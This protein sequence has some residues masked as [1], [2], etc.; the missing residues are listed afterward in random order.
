M[1]EI[2]FRT[3]DTVLKKWNL[4]TTIDCFGTVQEYKYNGHSYNAK[5]A[6]EYN[7]DE[8]GHLLTD[9]NL[10]FI[11]Q[12]YTGFKDNTGKEVYEGDI[13]KIKIQND[14]QENFYTVESLEELY[15]EINR[16]ESYYRITEIEIVGNNCEN[17]N[18][19]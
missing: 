13:L 3:W 5:Y 4:S 9:G 18:L 19:L 10:R 11:V 17:L 8:K 2:K 15:F 12:Q 7:E 14:W 16:D 1:R 6:D